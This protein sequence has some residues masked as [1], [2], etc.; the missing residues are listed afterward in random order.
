M[1]LEKGINTMEKCAELQRDYIE[2]FNHLASVA[3][4]HKSGSATLRDYI[5]AAQSFEV[6]S[7]KLETEGGQ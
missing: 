4:R 2:K 1:H 3:E 5:E 6:A 7:I